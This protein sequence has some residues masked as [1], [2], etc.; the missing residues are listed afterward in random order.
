MERISAM[1]SSARSGY[2]RVA[3]IRRSF[4]SAS[5]SQNQARREV[6]PI[7]Y[8]DKIFVRIVNMQRGWRTIADFSLD[9]VND[10]TEVYGE[11]RWR[12]RGERGLTRLYIR[13]ATR[14]WCYEQPFML[15]SER[16]IASA[17][18]TEPATLSAS[19][20]QSVTARSG[21]REIP[22]SVRLYCGM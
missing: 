1:Q 13:N 2:G 15:Y 14:G 7:R 19:A 8:G 9:N 21:R 12:T 22:E 4:D 11:L 5:R 10:M 20:P 3:G 18:H 17:I 6:R 16:R